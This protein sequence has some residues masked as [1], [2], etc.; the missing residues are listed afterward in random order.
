MMPRRTPPRLLWTALLVLMLG[1]GARPAETLETRIDRILD[2]EPVATAFWGVY[3]RD[4]ASGRVLYARNADK[5]F[6]PASNQKL[7][8]TATALDALGPAYRYQTTL[9]LDGEADGATL[10]GDLIV[11]GAGDPSFGSRKLGGNDPIRAWANALA[12]MGVRRIEGRLIGDD[13]RFDDDAYAA[14]WDVSYLRTESY[15][16]PPGG[17]A[18]RDNLVQVRVEATRPGEAPR[19]ETAP[20]D[21]FTVRN[22]SVTGSRSRGLGPRVDRRLGD[23]EARLYG[24]IPRT[25]AG[26][27]VLPAADPTAMVL[28]AFAQALSEAGITVEATRHDVDD[29]GE[30]EKPDYEAARPLFVHVSP[31][32]AELAAVINKESDNLYA[33]QVF[34]TFGWG[35]SYEG[36]GRRVKS[37]LARFGAPTDGLSI[38]DGSGLSRKDLVTPEA[39][40]LLLAGM[41]EHEAADAFTASMAAGGEPRTTL[42][43]RLRGASVRAKTGSLE[44]ARTLSGYATSADGRRLSFVVMANHYTA[45]A[46]RI[47]QAIDS[48]VLTLSTATVGDAGGDAP[49]APSKT[50]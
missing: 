34:R 39:L 6:I 43:H 29:L 20:A 36:G 21:Y 24:E 31:P 46:Y 41:A 18:Y 1:L 19:V 49:E 8:T 14:G 50:P 16:P 3:V 25:Y 28:H 37:L 32:L 38:Q 26:T 9:Y 33:E 10:R 5:A 40:G 42:Q 11:E 44:Y 23:D 27:I 2:A 48:V 30:A 7:L 22:Q 35:G 13:D 45:P 47:Q 12:T 4:L 17:L 15:A